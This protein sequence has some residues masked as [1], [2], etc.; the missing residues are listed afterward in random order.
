[1][2][3]STLLVGGKSKKKSVNLG[4]LARGEADPGSAA[5]YTMDRPGPVI[6]MYVCVG[7]V[8]HSL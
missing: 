8:S 4:D 6:C 3:E 1:M 7:T 5:V 2:V